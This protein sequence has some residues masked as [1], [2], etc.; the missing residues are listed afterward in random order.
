MGMRSSQRFDS[1]SGSRLDALL[2]RFYPIPGFTKWFVI[3]CGI[4]LLAGI[5]S[6][7]LLWALEWATDW[8][9]AYQGWPIV[10]LPMGGLL[11]GWMYH[12]YGQSVE[13]GNNLLLEEIHNPK[14]T[15]PLR[16]APMVLA[17]TTLSHL[18]GASV[19][20]EGTALQI[21][22]SLVDQL[23]HVVKFQPRDR[24]TLLMAALSAGFASV[25]GTPLA[26]TVFGLE[27]LS[28]GTISHQ[29]LFP[30]LIAAI[31]G[32]R[33]TLLL[34]LKHTHYPHAESLAITPVTLLSAMVAGAIFGLTAMAFAKLT[35]T[36]SQSFKTRIANPVLRP[37]IGGFIVAGIMVAIESLFHTTKYMGLGIPTLVNAFETPLPPWDFA[38]K[39]GLTALSLGAGFKGGEVTP[40]FF[41]GA[42]LGNALSGVLP[43]SM[44]LLAGMGFVAVFGGAANTPIAATLMGIELFGAESG[45]YMAIACVMSYLFSGQTGI[46]RSQRLG[47]RKYD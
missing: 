25:F 38:T 46:Y 11:S 19:G 4:G 36:L 28:I 12:R 10:L 31:V 22:A 13:A 2:K 23:T 3:A 37:A 1:R 30:C 41:M 35:H 27:V 39:L 18:L 24:R 33:F 44:P 47:T 45:V 34:G 20:R 40:L 29:A 26:G 32:D 17:G 5:G 7:A 14:S 8:R 6:A 15:I 9:E 21:A 42:T 43:L 16:M